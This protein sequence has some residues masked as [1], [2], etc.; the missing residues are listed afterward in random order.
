MGPEVNKFEQ[1]SSD[2]NQMSLAA[3]GPGGFPEVTCPMDQGWGIPE[4]PF[5][6]GARGP[7]QGVPLHHR[8]GH[9][10]TPLPP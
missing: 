5:P 7:V 4:V 9:M 3:G 10:G 2:G 6:R 8:Y 1:V